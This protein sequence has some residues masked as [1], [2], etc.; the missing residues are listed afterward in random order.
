MHATLQVKFLSIK[1][2]LKIKR[3]CVLVHAMK[4]YRGSNG[5]TPP[6]LTW[7]LDGGEWLTSHSSRFAPAKEPRYPLNMNVGGLERRSGLIK[8]ETNPSSGSA[9]EPKIVQ[10]VV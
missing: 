2:H 7:A 9:F 5:I 3:K 6:F 8:E 1:S 4:A 10:Q